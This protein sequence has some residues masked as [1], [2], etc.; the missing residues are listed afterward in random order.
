MDYLL[1]KE[2]KGTLDDFKS[3]LKEIDGSP[4]IASIRNYLGSWTQMKAE[5][6]TRLINNEEI[7]PVPYEGISGG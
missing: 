5:A 6:L 3:Y 2:T 1:D 4:S 7:V